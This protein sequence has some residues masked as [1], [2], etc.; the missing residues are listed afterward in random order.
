MASRPSRNLQIFYVSVLLLA[1]CSAPLFVRAYM[2]SSTSTSTSISPDNATIIL[3]DTVTFTATVTATKG[4]PTGL[5]TFVDGNTPLGSG[6]LQNVGGNMQ[7]TFS[8]SILSAAASPHSITATYDGDPTHD[9]SS[10]TTPETVNAR[11]S[12]TGVALNPTTVVVGQSS[13]ATVTVT[14][15]GSVPPG[16]ADTFTM[17]GAPATGRTGFT[18]TL[19]ADGLVLVAGGTDANNTVLQSAE[20]YSVS[21]GTF[22]STGALNAA[23]TGAVAVLLPNGKVLVAGGSSDGTAGGALNTA[24]LFDPSAGTFTPT[25]HNMIVARFGATATLLNTGAVLIAGG[26]DATPAVQNTAELYDPTADTFTA[27]GNLNAA[28]TGHSATLLGTDMNAKVLIAGGSSGGTANGALNSA[29]VF[30]P[31]GNSGAGTFTSVAGANPTLSDD[32]WQPEAA[33][34]LSGKVLIAGGQNSGGALTSADLYDPVADSFTASNNSMSQARANG[35]AVALPNGMVLLAGGTTSQAVDLYDADSDQ[36]DTTGSLQQSDSGLISTLL[37]NGDVLVVGLTTATTPASDSE[38]YAPSFNPLGTVAVTSSEVTDGINGACT[39]APSSS[40]AST[41]TSTIT[42]ANIGTSPHIITATYPA[43]AVHSGSS[44]TANLT[45]HTSNTTTTVTSSVNPSVFGQPVTFTATVSATSGGTPTGTVTFFDGG[46][47]I[48]TENLS[49]GVATL[50]TSA[51]AAGSH[52]ITASYGGHGN[53]SGSIGSLTG[54]PQV[55]NKADTTTTVTSSA[56]PSVFGQSV[57]FTATISSVA[58]GAGTASGTVTFLDGGNS[59]GTG[60][61]SGGVAT[62]TTSALAVTSHTITTSYNGDGDFNGSTGS[63]TGN[64]QVVNKADTTTTVTS[65]ANPSVFGQSVTFT[66]TISPV[67]PG[68]GTA[69]GIVTFL[70]GGNSIGTGNLSGGV[71][72]LTTSALAVTSHT[73]TTSY[74]GDGNFNGSTGSLTGNP[75]VVNKDNTTITITAHSPSP[76]DVNQTV[77]VSASLAAK[78]P[79]SGTPTGSVSVSDGAGET[80]TITLTSGAGSCSL[81]PQVA[82]TDTLTAQYSGDGNFNG[83]TSPGVSQTVNTRHTTTTVALNPSSIVVNQQ[84]TVTVTVTD[85]DLNGTAESPT[86]SVTVTSDSGGDNTSDA[87]VG[88]PCTLSSTTTGVSTCQVTIR[89]PGKGSSPHTV[90][91][92]YAGTHVHTAS[93]GSAA[94]TVTTR[95]THT[96]VMLN[97]ASVVVN[98]TSTVT[99]TVTDDDPDTAD[100]VSPTGTVAVSSDSGGDASTDTITGTCSLTATTTGV[101]TC[102]VAIKPKGKGSGTHNITVSYSGTDVH[103]ASNNNPGTTLTV[104][105]RHTTTTVNFSINPVKIST[106]LVVTTTVMD[107]DPNGSPLAPAG[108]INL[109]SSEATDSLSSPTCPLSGSGAATSC[110][111]KLIAP[112]FAGG[113]HTIS[114][115]YAQDD[116]HTA[117]NTV[118]A[119]SALAVQPADTVTVIPSATDL[120]DFLK[121]FSGQQVTFTATVT[122]NDLNSAAA[123]LGN[124]QFLVDGNSIG[125]TAVIPSNTNLS[126]STTFTATLAQISQA[127][128]STASHSITAKFVPNTDFVTSTS[129]DAVAMTVTPSITNIPGQTIASQ[130][131]LLDSVGTTGNVTFQCTVQL[132]GSSIPTSQQ[133]NF[134]LCKITPT[135]G[136]LPATITATLTTFATASSRVNAAPSIYASNRHPIGFY[137]LSTPLAGILGLLLLGGRRRKFWSRRKLF[138]LV[139]MM[140]LLAVLGVA[141]GCGGGF[142]NPNNLQPLTNGTQ[143]GVY[144]VSVIGSDS[145]GNVVAIGVIPLTV[146]L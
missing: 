72:T 37:N 41:C 130:Q 23:R 116:Q 107:D 35:S 141:V 74:N 61:L 90:T 3:G 103:A 15:S 129:T 113:Q 44:D 78:A 82:G 2:F 75:Q 139:G 47:S 105:T 56:N 43:D 53:H 63:L 85:D 70:D 5:V 16:T 9:P 24:E 135:S 120:T 131:L 119:N 54:N 11:T 140:L 146:Q 52:T 59:I 64:P 125:T 115:S 27:T 69:S 118:P 123:P 1:V 99:V 12:A 134:P 13:T 79:G 133:T 8:T 36:F 39:L 50:N 93:T 142:N 20:I 102:Q 137:A 4:T 95:H 128:T 98:Q 111:I 112:H 145:N 33:F 6:I 96:A 87:I 57:T 144:V 83:S 25:S 31:T 108:T 76:S 127:Q 84:S 122:N 67:A 136:T 132:L 138:S 30:D 62:L 92:S 81:T 97:S 28:R 101:S 48:G 86:G 66:A 60:N 77:N 7:A 14:D 34:L 29:E 110:T 94:L 89:P 65:S 143:Q 21:N 55:V 114:A 104:N 45:V 10:G 91:A 73:I 121:N 17:T 46:N 68:A 40:T 124:M 42:P 32:R 58:P 22:S 106:Q 49:G 100:P 71:A 26:Q 109:S 38:L 19:F 51:L 126:S 18:S 117:S 88:S 80:C